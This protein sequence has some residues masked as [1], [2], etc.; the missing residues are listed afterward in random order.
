MR[1]PICLHCGEKIT[2]FGRGHKYKIQKY[3]G[4]FVHFDCYTRWQYEKKQI[5]KLP[6]EPSIRKKYSRTYYLKH[7]EEIIQK[8]M[9]YQAR[10]KQKELIV[11]ESR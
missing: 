7:R 10:M 1:K 2:H 5:N 8:T 11:V 3:L 9:A 6:V 4:G